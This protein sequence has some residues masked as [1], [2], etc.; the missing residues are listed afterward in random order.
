MP[1]EISHMIRELMRKEFGEMGENILNKQCRKMGVMPNEICVDDLEELSESVFN[2]VRYFMGTD[3]AK[4]VKEGIRRYI[5][6]QELWDLDGL[7][8]NDIRTIKECKLR[9]ELGRTTLENLGDMEEALEYYTRAADIARGLGRNDLY[10]EALKGIC[11]T[12]L[13]L[14]DLTESIDAG[15]NGMEISKKERL[16]EIYAECKRGIGI[17]HWRKG[18]FNRALSHLDKVKDIYEEMEDKLNIAK[19][20]RNLGDIH[21]EFKKYDV[22]LEY[23]K[24]SADI[25]GDRG[26]ALERAVLLM[27]MGVVYTI[28]DEWEKAVEYYKKSEKISREGKL[29]NALAWNLFNLGQAYTDLKKFNDA[30][31]ALDESL[32]LF[33]TQQDRLGESGVQIRYGLLWIERGDIERGAQYLKDGIEVLRELDMLKYLADYTHEL[34]KAEI[35][36]GEYESAEEHLNEALE[37]YERIDIQENVEAVKKDLNELT[38]YLK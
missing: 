14:G 27:N 23:Y 6:L 8:K 4:K 10:A 11:F 31:K 18:D 25:F 35:E 5:L 12:C 3:R 33:E 21:G 9:L 19:I 38:K 28:K 29:P 16:Q 26:N 37:I 13:G 17:C 7:E 20:Y 24:K 2:S 1:R 30:E 34:A 32:E 36:L 22:S 15:K